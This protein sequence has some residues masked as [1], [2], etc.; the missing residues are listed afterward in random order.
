MFNLDKAASAPKY[1]LVTPESRLQL[2]WTTLESLRQVDQRYNYKPKSS[3]GD[4]SMKLEQHWIW[5][6]GQTKE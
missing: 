5:N 6:F 3:M 1:R 2:Y 4:G